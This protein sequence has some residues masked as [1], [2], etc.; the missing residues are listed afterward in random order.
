[1]FRILGSVF[2]LPIFSKASDFR[3]YQLPSSYVL[4]G[5]VAVKT[6]VARTSTECMAHAI[7]V[8]GDMS[9]FTYHARTLDCSIFA[10]MLNYTITSRASEGSNSI[11]TMVNGGALDDDGTEPCRSEQSLRR[12]LDSLSSGPGTEPGHSPTEEE[13]TTPSVAGTI[14]RGT[15]VNKTTPRRNKLSCPVL[16]QSTTNRPA[17]NMPNSAQYAPLLLDSATFSSGQPAVAGRLSRSSAPNASS[18]TYLGQCDCENGFTKKFFKPMNASDKVE[19]TCGSNAKNALLYICD[20]DG[21]CRRF[22]DPAPRYLRLSTECDGTGCTFTA[23]PVAQQGLSQTF[24]KA[25]KNVTSIGC[26]GETEVQKTSLCF[27][28]IKAG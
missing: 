18:E 17:C 9:Y 8:Y 14:S 6:T 20:T 3:F 4:A 12:L 22:G 11:V 19:L 25:L 1:M 27:G 16:R 2:F 28:P 7:D 13:M 21:K 26:G 24:F 15:T 10:C 23:L 5:D